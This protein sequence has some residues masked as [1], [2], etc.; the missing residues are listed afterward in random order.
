MHIRRLSLLVALIIIFVLTGIAFLMSVLG[1]D[2]VTGSAVGT[3]AVQPIRLSI[4]LPG[5]LFIG[6]V[7]LTIFYLEKK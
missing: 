7:L 3:S 6:F 4:V 1:G 2:P 5:L